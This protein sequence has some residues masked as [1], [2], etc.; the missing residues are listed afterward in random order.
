MYW[1]KKYISNSVIYMSIFCKI[2][3]LKSSSPICLGHRSLKEGR[4]RGR[5]AE[6]IGEEDCEWAARLAEEGGPDEGW[7]KSFICSS[8]YQFHNIQIILHNIWLNSI[9]FPLSLN[10]KFREL[11]FEERGE[12]LEQVATH[13]PGVI[14]DLMDLRMPI[15]GSQTEEWPAVTPAWIARRCPLTWRW[16]AVGRAPTDVWAEQHTWTFCLGEGILCLFQIVRNYMLW[17]IPFGSTT[18]DRS[19]FRLQNTWIEKILH[20]TTDAISTLHYS[21]YSIQ[22]MFT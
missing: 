20:L 18:R 4:G 16:S 11:S 14:F 13:L 15:S 21:I 1:N 2:P 7:W 5:A 19:K 17:H 9:F 22:M 3:V 6:R 12:V 8:V 10:S